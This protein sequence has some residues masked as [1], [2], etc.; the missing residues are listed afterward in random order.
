MTLFLLCI[1]IFLAR[2]T[3]VTLG[4][5]RTIYT[6]RGK[7]VIAGVIAFIEV[8]IWFVIARE[9]LNTDLQSIWIVIAYSGGYAT[10]T[11]LGT[12]IANNFV[13]S[14]I[15]IEVITTKATIDNINK[16]R[17]EG[18]GVSVVNTVENINDEKTKI[19]YITLN[20]RNLEKLK[21]IIKEIDPS[22]FLVIKESKIVQNGYIK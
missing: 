10:G 9:A 6:V 3:D 11:I 13:N 2:I 15:S 21:R 18:Y 20:S 19:L 22:A 16:I 7:T 8:F 12:F 1:K 17:K 14:L 4:T 5:L